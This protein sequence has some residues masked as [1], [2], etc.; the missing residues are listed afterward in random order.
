MFEF[1]WS[2]APVAAIATPC[3]GVCE[4]GDDG[5]CEGCFRTGDE[6][7]AWSGMSDQQRASLMNEILP[8]RESERR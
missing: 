8:L 2:S 7:A 3:I 1:R 6:I 5:L 4:L